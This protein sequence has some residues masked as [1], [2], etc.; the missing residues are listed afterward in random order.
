MHPEQPSQLTAVHPGGKVLPQLGH[1]VHQLFN[2]ASPVQQ[3]IFRMQMQMRK[4]GH[5]YLDSSRQATLR[6]PPERRLKSR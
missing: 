5:G 1:P 6:D 3:G 4:F 2:V